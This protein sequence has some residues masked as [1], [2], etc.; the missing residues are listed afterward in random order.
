[1]ASNFI[2]AFAQG[3]SI[4]FNKT[5]TT[6]S[7]HAPEVGA[8]ENP[9]VLESVSDLASD[10]IASKLF[11]D[12]IFQLTLKKDLSVEDHSAIEALIERMHQINTQGLHPITMYFHRHLGLRK[13]LS[14]DT[15]PRLKKDPEFVLA[16]LRK[17]AHIYSDKTKACELFRFIDPAL[18]AHPAFVRKIFEEGFNVFEYIDS[19]LKNNPDFVLELIDE[20]PNFVKS[21]V[22]PSELFQIEG[23]VKGYL[24][25]FP[26]DIRKMKPEFQRNRDIV[27]AAMSANPAVFSQLVEEF[28]DDESIAV[29]AIGYRG[30]LYRHAS[31]RLKKNEAFARCAI[32]N[33]PTIYEDLEPE[34]KA[35]KEYLLHSI[36]HCKFAP[37]FLQ[38]APEC[39]IT[40]LAVI[41]EACMLKGESFKYLKPEFKDKGGVLFEA[42]STYPSA[43]LYAST[44][45]RGNKALAMKAL[46][47][48]P[49]NFLLI[50]NRMSED[51]QQD[52]DIILEI[53][54]QHVLHRA[55]FSIAIDLDLRND[56]SFILSLLEMSPSAI[57][58]A[59]SELLDDEGFLLH[60]FTRFPSI[61]YE[62]CFPIET[63]EDE[64]FVGKL[65]NFDKSLLQDMH[66]S[67]RSNED[68]LDPF[69]NETPSLFL[70]ADKSLQ[71]VS[72]AMD[73]LAQEPTLYLSL[74]LELKLNHEVALLA[75]ELSDQ[76]IDTFIH[77]DLKKDP[78]FAL[79]LF[80]ESPSDILWLDL[81][82][83][84]SD[85]NFV[86]Q[87]L[88]LE[89]F[90]RGVII[91]HITADMKRNKEV[92]IALVEF[93]P[94]LYSSLDPEI[95][96]D[97]D[98][99]KNALEKDGLNLRFAP[100][101]V[102]NNY[103]LAFV[104]V[105]QCGSALQ[106]LSGDFRDD[107]ALV[108]QA[109]SNQLDAFKYASERL[110]GEKSF[111]IPV[112]AQKPEL[113]TSV[114]PH[115][116][117]DA[118][119]GMIVVQQ[120]GMLIEHLTNELKQNPDIAL[121]ALRSTHHAARFIHPSLYNH[122]EVRT[123]LLQRY[124]QTIGGVKY[125][126]SRVPHAI[127]EEIAEA[128]APPAG[129]SFERLL[130]EDL[131][132]FI[133][134]LTAEDLGVPPE[135]LESRKVSLRGT[136]ETLKSRI[137]G[138]IPFLGTP[139]AA[140]QEHILAFYEH[141]KA[142]LSHIDARL[143]DR[144]DMKAE[145]IQ[146]LQ[147]AGV[148]GGGLLG[149]LQQLHYQLCS[150]NAGLSCAAQLAKWRNDFIIRFVDDLLHQLAV[151]NHHAPDVHHKNMLMHQLSYFLAGIQTH[152][153]HLAHPFSPFHILARL[154]RHQGAATLVSSLKED[155]LTNEDLKD[156]VIEFVEEDMFDGL[157]ST[158][159]IDAILIEEKSQAASSF[160]K[161]RTLAEALKVPNGEEGTLVAMD[162]Q[163]CQIIQ[164]SF[165]Q[166][167]CKARLTQHLNRVVTDEEAELHYSKKPLIQELTGEYITLKLLSGV[168]KEEL[169][170]MSAAQFLERVEAHR[171]ERVKYHQKDMFMDILRDEEG[172]FKDEGLA[173]LLERVGLLNKL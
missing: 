76:D 50:F 39:L 73:L 6:M 134:T 127:L 44:R 171:I 103:D 158:P 98:I 113:I 79:G 91:P 55:L 12:F 77:P 19:S 61:V 67:I 17:Y 37:D 22:I 16:S 130:V 168:S 43:F 162:P 56:P 164:F 69:F 21:W 136:I 92:A 18:K 72:R 48:D 68:L 46:S 155:L 54:R 156:K 105:T 173:V 23:F 53:F 36:K 4:I 24:Q 107:E 65:L 51:L 81:P 140:H 8:P 28:L 118:E 85:V 146:I 170:G 116:L 35:K 52:R 114:S 83:L 1:M 120:N 40:D 121:A 172:R 119:V 7:L 152:N 90:Y 88:N 165:S 66:P 29:Q 112:L 59:S 111:V 143:H 151:A 153:D 157:H 32:L 167:F 49:S 33:D 15:D 26:F 93:R 137:D 169:S 166:G 2:N 138:N 75:L 70:L 125:Q 11:R 135:L 87:V 161:I 58:L 82:F 13:D 124:Y 84:C 104:A 133:D 144:A 160:E 128:S 34:F 132:A 38:E 27:N 145:R 14:E 45:L 64:E 60:A 142:Y 96:A 31:T 5:F 163:V 139:P 148:C 109:L 80:D 86:L 117:N 9:L 159:E 20:D 78:N 115:L 97:V 74:P 62:S 94:S 122:P 126:L 131:P 89:T 102:Q 47:K 123:L 110:R 129:G 41:M 99:A 10:S 106:Y 3:Q 63:I 25:Y 147:A 71:T 141:I 95:Q 100:P 42:L 149:Q 150:D 108:S 57:L 154:Q 101:S 30:N